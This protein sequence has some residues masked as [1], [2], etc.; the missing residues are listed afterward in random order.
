MQEK[1]AEAHRQISNL[2]YHMVN[3]EV[4]GQVH[5]RHQEFLIKHAGSALSSELVKLLSHFDM[6]PEDLPW[7][8]DREQAKNSLLNW[9]RMKRNSVIMI[10]EAYMSVFEKRLLSENL[11]FKE[12]ELYDEHGSESSKAV[13]L[14]DGDE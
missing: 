4:R 11:K 10:V 13:G 7:V 8:E 6:P 2:R 3:P 12:K 5:L 14:F 1:F 9:T